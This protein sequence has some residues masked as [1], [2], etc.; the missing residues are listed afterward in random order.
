M[1][2][3]I[4]CSAHVGQHDECN[5]WKLTAELLR[6]LVQEINLL[7]NACVKTNNQIMLWLEFTTLLSVSHSLVSAHTSL[8]TRVPMIY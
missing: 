6:S 1:F 7:E 5:E 8:S 3:Y 2:A 4:R